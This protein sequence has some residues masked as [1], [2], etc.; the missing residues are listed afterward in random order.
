MPRGHFRCL[1]FSLNL[2]L[3]VANDFS[4]C[5]LSQT[6][7]KDDFPLRGRT[8]HRRLTNDKR[9]LSIPRRQKVVFDVRSKLICT[10][11]HKD[12]LSI[13]V[14]LEIFLTVTHCYCY[15]HMC[16]AHCPCAAKSRPMRHKAINPNIP[17]SQMPNVQTRHFRRIKSDS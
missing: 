5:C 17:T 10:V 11:S 14:S 1:R 15:Q 16:A 3:F 2:I 6:V 7:I 12:A 4:F 13:A 9:N 8:R